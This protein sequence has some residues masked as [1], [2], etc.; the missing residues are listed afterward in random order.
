V[1][2]RWP[3]SVRVGWAG[4]ALSI[5]VPADVVIEIHPEDP[6]AV[7]RWLQARVAELADEERM[8]NAS[9][10]GRRLAHTDADTQR[11]QLLATTNKPARVAVVVTVRARSR[12]ELQ[13][14]VATVRHRF[15]IALAD[16]RPCNGEHDLGRLATEVGGSVRV[17]QAFK[18]LDCL[19]AASCYPFLP[20]TLDHDRGVLVGVTTEGAMGVRLDPFDASLESFG[21]VII[22]KTG[23]GKS[24]W[25]KCLVYA[26]LERFGYDVVLIEQRRTAEHDQL[27]W[28][29]GGRY[30]F[31]DG[32][33]ASLTGRCGRACAPRTATRPSRC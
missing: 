19:S 14:R 13:E 29:C 8:A 31:W 30:V 25:I 33:A 9:N 16:V 3:R 5:D 4:L 18:R 15:G 1:L 26:L 6:D 11:E 22:A 12:A 24:Y 10:A 20:V 2:R 27:V 32:Q 28:R 23:A 7:A 17:L 21:G